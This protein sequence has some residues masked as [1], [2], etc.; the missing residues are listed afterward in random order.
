MVLGYNADS[1]MRMYVPSLALSA[2][3][4]LASCSIRNSAQARS[5]S[6]IQ[7]LYRTAR[8]ID[9]DIATGVSF[10]R[11]RQDVADLATSVLIAQDSGQRES[12][13]SG[14]INKY[15][16]LVQKHQDALYVWSLTISDEAAHATDPRLMQI[17]GKYGI[18]TPTKENLFAY[19]RDRIWA[20]ISA[21]EKQIVSVYE[22]EQSMGL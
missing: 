2:C 4:L 21:D 22:S 12:A 20:M 17:Q 5:Q 14:L 15:A 8:H 16:D 10:D 3:V 13:H 6:E 11:Y 19:I 18:E 1:H 9:A 7:D